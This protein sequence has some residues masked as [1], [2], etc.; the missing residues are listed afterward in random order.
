MKSDKEILK[1]VGMFK[2]KHFKTKES[3]KAS[4]L[5]NKQMINC[6]KIGFK[7]SCVEIVK[8]ASEQALKTIK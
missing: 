1:I 7:D 5:L 4:K 3:R 6:Y 8:S 2:A